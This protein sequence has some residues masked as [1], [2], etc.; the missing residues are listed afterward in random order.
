MP[1]L[2]H[3]RNQCIHCGV[4][5]SVCPEFFKDMGEIT[6][7]GASYDNNIGMLK[8][9]EE[10]KPVVQNAVDVCPVGCIKIE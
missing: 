5:T 8:I 2:S 3:D 10:Q 4:C 9:T 1:K 7:K 6:L